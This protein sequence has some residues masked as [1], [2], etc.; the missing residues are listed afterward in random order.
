MKLMLKLKNIG[1]KNKLIAVL[2]TNVLVSA[3][4]TLNGK[5]AYILQK[6]ISGELQLCHN[7]QILIEYREVLL[8]PKFKFKNWQVNFLLETIEKDGI[9]VIPTTLPDIKFVDESDRIFYEVAK[10]CN[11]LLVTGNLKHFPDDDCIM[12]VSDFYQSIIQ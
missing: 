7:Y 3:L 10:F 1:V 2:D 9:S 11:T 12:T 6:V 5:A 4:W 8:C